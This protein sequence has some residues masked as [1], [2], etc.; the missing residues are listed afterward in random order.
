[1]GPISPIGG[2][3]SPQ[4]SAGAAP[5]PA[6]VAGGASS[7]G[8]SS[9]GSLSDGKGADAAMPVEIAPD[10][11]SSAGEPLA[12]AT[13]TIS[14]KS[15]TYTSSVVYRRVGLGVDGDNTMRALIALLVLPARLTEEQ[16]GDEVLH[17]LALL[18]AAEGLG[19]SS[20]AVSSVYLSMS[21]QSAEVSITQTQAIESL[22]GSGSGGTPETGGTID[23]Q[24]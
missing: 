13:M 3:P 17:G 4:S 12:G 1:M 11:K 7:P 8:I 14:T 16:D 21:H 15:E 23:I 5:P 2:Q 20:A 18:Q 10:G 6:P 24:V 22:A 19:G 9:A